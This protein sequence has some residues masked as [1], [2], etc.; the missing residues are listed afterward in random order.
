MRAQADAY[1]LLCAAILGD[2][3]QDWRRRAACRFMPPEKFFPARNES[4]AEAKA[5]CG[6]CPVR[7]QC[8][9]DAL[10]R[11]DRW[12]IWGGLNEGERR[13]VRQERVRG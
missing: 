3:R 2:D 6:G 12:G 5:A 9:Q 13:Q 4:S 8:L 11:S 10:S 1:G 7:E